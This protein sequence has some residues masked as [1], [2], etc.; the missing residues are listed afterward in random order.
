M[1]RRGKAQSQ[2][3]GGKGYVDAQGE[4]PVMA[5]AEIGWIQ[6]KECQ[7]SWQQPGAKKAREDYPLEPS[8]SN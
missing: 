4:C 3:P 8:Q 1:V 2:T 7:C 5:E 6:A